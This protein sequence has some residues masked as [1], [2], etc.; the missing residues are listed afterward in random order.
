VGPLFLKDVCAA[1]CC[2]SSTSRYRVSFRWFGWLVG[3]QVDRAVKVLERATQ[4][5]GPLL[6]GY[7]SLN[8]DPVGGSPVTMGAFCDSFYEYLLKVGVH[9]CSSGRNAQA[10]RLLASRLPL[11]LM[12]TAPCFLPIVRAAV[13][14]RWQEG[15]HVRSDVH[16][17][18]R[19]DDR[20]PHQEDQ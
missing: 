19:V 16:P 3:L 12:R 20:S 11:T 7:I 14:S 4:S 13:A 2:F 9:A 8:G 5:Y 18:R 1:E 10:R 15:V 17:R 6:P